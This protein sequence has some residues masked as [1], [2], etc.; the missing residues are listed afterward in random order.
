MNNIVLRSAG[1][2]LVLLLLVAW[3]WSLSADPASKNLVFSL[4]TGTAFGIVLQRARFCFLC[5]FRD[6]LDDRDPRGLI[7]IAVALA[8]GAVLYFIVLMA[9]VPVPQPERLPPN[10]HVGPVG[11]V[12]AAG[13][14]VFGLGMAIS[15]SCLSGHFYRLGEG[16]PTSPFAL[17]GAAFGFL[18]GFLSWNRLYLWS[19]SESRPVWLPFELGYAGA[20]AATLAVLGAVI[21]VLAATGRWNA[22]QGMEPGLAA[23][24]R[25]VFVDRWPAAV[26]GLAVAAISALYYFRVAPLGVTAELGSLVRTAGSSHELLPETLLGLDTLRGC[27]TVVKETLLS[28]NG[29]LVVGLVLGSFAAALVGGQFRPALPTRAQIAKGLVG[30]V[31]MGWGA[32]VSLG[33]TVGVLLSGIHAGALSGW[34]FLVC[35]T[36]G[37][38][39][40]LSTMRR[41][42]WR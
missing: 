2:S 30:G 1:A 39:L 29:L 34:V 10:A 9:W 11:I 7:A 4:L 31:L 40:G 3:A 12:L 8:A 33:C 6:Y 42:G 18:L 35:C 20:L 27:A 15:G 23:L 19:V 28:P 24:G 14:F 25:A 16:S 21:A 5:N 41:V 22:R 38:W 32:M 37:V 36:L 17:A 13:S 26:G